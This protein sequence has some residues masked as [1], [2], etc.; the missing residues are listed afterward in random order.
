MIDQN[1]LNKLKAINQLP[2]NRRA[3]ELM[4][5]HGEKI[6]GHWIHAVQATQLAIDQ[7]LVQ[8]GN[9]QLKQALALIDETKDPQRIAKILNLENTEPVQNLTEL[10]NRVL[11]LLDLHLTETAEGYPNLQA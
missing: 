1:Y 7:G 6:L 3:Y 4:I 8:I 11:M 2:I 10:A 9:P 5:R